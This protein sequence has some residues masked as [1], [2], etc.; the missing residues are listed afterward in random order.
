MLKDQRT[1]IIGDIEFKVL[2]SRRRSIGISVLPDSRVIL[3]VPYLTSFNTI[4]R[5]V[6]EKSDW[7]IKHRD[8]YKR[9]EPRRLNRLYVSGETHL[10]RGNEYILQIEKSRKNYIKFY[11][12]TIEVGTGKADNS[13][14]IKKLLYEGYKNEAS[15]VFPEIMNKVLKQFE[16]Q[17]FKPAKLIIRTMKRR[18][19]SCSNRG[20][21]TLS[22][23]LIKLPDL[24][25]EYVIIHELCHLKHHNHGAGYYK[26]L[27]ELFPDW[28]KVRKELRNYISH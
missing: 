1:H 5:I 8:I 11:D 19:G 16:V 20:I 18:W 6:R 15:I 9:N 24:Y 4:S 27:S 21:I 23:E 14:A 13:V 3:R 17:K 10:F 22:T 25:I 2:Y 7:I 28:K 12:N 26:L